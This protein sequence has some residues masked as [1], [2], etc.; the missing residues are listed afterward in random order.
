MGATSGNENSFARSLIDPM[1]LY[2]KLLQQLATLL[3][4]QIE[5]LPVDRIID[6][7]SLVVLAEI[8]T[9]SLS[10]L[11]AEYVPGCASRCA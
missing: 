7:G 4:I 3:A 2:A 11:R 6:I 5:G 10:V 8:L 9:N 1:A